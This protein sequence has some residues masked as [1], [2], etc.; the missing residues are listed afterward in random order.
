MVFH[1]LISWKTMSNCEK[2]MSKLCVTIFLMP[3]TNRDIQILTLNKK[4]C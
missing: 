3:L 2:K 1:D 4:V